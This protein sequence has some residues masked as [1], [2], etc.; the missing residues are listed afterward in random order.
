MNRF[1]FTL[2]YI[3]LITSLYAQEK[4][5]PWLQDLLAAQA[6]PLFKHVLNHKDSFQYQVIYTQID[7]NRR[8]R[9]SFK[10]Y[11]LN[12]DKNRYFNPASTVKL[13]VVLAGLEKINDLEVKG[14][15]KYTPMLTDSGYTG[16]TRVTTDTSSQNG[17]PSVA[18]YAKKVFLVSDNDAYN[19]LYEFVG[20]QRLNET[21]WQKGYTHSRITR[22]FVPMSPEENRYT[23]PIRFVH[24]G[25]VVYQQ[26]LT[27]SKI[28]FDFSKPIL[29]GN[30]HYNRE[31]KLIN[32]P[33]DF[34]TH[35]NFPLQDLQQML[36]SVL[37]PESV[38]EKQRFRL[39]KDDYR[40]LYQYMSMLPSQ[41]K[42][43]NYDT[44]EFFDSYT[45]FLYKNGKSKIPSHLRI[46]NKTGW[47]YGFLTDASYVI[48]LENKVEYMITAVIYV[49]RDG[50]L[51]DN[52]YEYTEIG[53][54]FFAELGR[55]LYE[56]ELA[57]TRK[58]RPRFNDFG[59]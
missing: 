49:N 13:P 31:D 51:N 32:T 27:Y 10:H 1:A 12:V 41:S 23:N 59:Y 24:K 38:S 50:V 8:N 46:F 47:S 21:L 18:H 48:D 20:Q 55:I 11:Y 40:F 54:P 2:L 33:M 3:F 34:T 25:R 45:K 16:Q 53:Y 30:A 42:Y 17:L 28:D 15:K 52:K 6:S 36:Q 58:Y 9:P 29:I 37:F 43:P 35:N 7:R 56:H 22:R 26:P 5:D 4:A 19:R 39:K 14:L 44:T 57:R